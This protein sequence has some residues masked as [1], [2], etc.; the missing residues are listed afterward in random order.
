MD[1][2]HGVSSMRGVVGGPLLLPPPPPLLLCLLI[3]PPAAS[4][5][6]L[7]AERKSPLHHVPIG[8]GQAGLAARRGANHSQVGLLVC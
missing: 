2:L 6:E 8:A 7:D 1:S 4:L 3:A 5:A